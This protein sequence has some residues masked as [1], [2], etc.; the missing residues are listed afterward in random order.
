MPL[1]D[2]D[3]LSAG[4][5]GKTILDGLSLSAERGDVVSLI[6][7]SGSGKSTLLRVLIGLTPPTGGTVRI[8]GEAISYADKAGLKSLRRRMSIVFQQFN[9]FQNMS[10]LDNLTLAPVRTLGV[11]RAEAEARARDLLANVGLADKAGSYPDQLSGGQQQRVAIARA[12]A[13]QPEILLLDEVTSALDPERVGEVLE[14]IRSLASTGI[15][16][17][18]VSHE[19]AFVREISTKVVMMDAGRVVEQGSPAAIF[20]TPTQARTKSFMQAIIRH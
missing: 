19:M 6:G 8:G 4:Y 16:M 10:V 2:I 11:A 18:L 15:T 5:G 13:M 7:P 20:K 1:L 14:T 3:N 12:L 9:L 17:L